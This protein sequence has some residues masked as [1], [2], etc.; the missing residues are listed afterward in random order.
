VRTLVV[1]NLISLDG[2]VSG[3]GD[4]LMAL[5]FDAAF[6]EAC[7]ERLRAADTLLLG[8]T[9]FMGFVNYWPPVVDD[10]DAREV[11]RE[12]SRRNNE[13]E[14]IV[15]SDTLTPDEAGPWRETTEIVGRADAHARVAALKEVDGGDILTFGSRTLWN[16]LLAAGLV[17]EIHLMVGPVVL[18]DGVPAFVRTPEAP[19]RLLDAP[20]TWEG[21]GN[22]LLR[23]GAT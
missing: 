11:E 13:I 4:D 8:R 12:I 17:D 1:H 22:V 9:S 23:Y 16:D 6:D 19:L 5:P 7:A 3:P 14:K 15:V 10:A 2:F 21:S 20:R 18:G